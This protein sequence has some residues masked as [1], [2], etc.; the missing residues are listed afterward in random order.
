M[1]ASSLLGA[2]CAAFVAAAPAVGQTYPERQISMVVP[3]SA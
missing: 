3:F 2:V 1:K